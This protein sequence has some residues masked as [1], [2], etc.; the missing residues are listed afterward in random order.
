VKLNKKSC[1]KPKTRQDWV[2]RFEEYFAAKHCTLFGQA[3]MVALP[4]E[5]RKTA[6]WYADLV[7]AVSKC[8]FGD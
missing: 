1:P 7:I 2:E 3:M 4:E 5:R 8:D 6:E